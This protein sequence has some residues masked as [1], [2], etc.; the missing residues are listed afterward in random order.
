[1]IILSGATGSGKT[2]VAKELDEIGF[3]II[4]TFTTRPPRENDD[5]T[6]C[7]SEEQFRSIDRAALFMATGTFD[8]KMGKIS[9]GIPIEPYLTRHSESVAILVQ[10]YMDDT[11]KY[12]TENT[13]D[14]LLRVYIEVDEETLIERSMKDDS[15]G[16]S[17]TD[18]K[19]RIIRDREKNNLLRDQADLIIVN[20]GFT[21]SPKEVAAC[22]IDDY[23]RLRKRKE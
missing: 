7:V 15:R 19:D 3:T 4:P 17:N 2:T 21:M 5:Y 16:K 6:V 22:I 1:M 8:S 12:V 10:E 23:K 14:T 18:L 11:I 13:N 9:Y 20:D